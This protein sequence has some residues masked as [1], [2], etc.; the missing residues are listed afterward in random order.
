VQLLFSGAIPGQADE[1]GVTALLGIFDP[2]SGGILHRCEYRPPAPLRVEGQKVQFTGF[3]FDGER[4]FVCSFG[5]I[6]IF[7]SWPPTR[8]A[9]RITHPGFNDLHHCLP[10]RGGLAV[11]NTGLETVDLVS[12]EGELLERWDLLEDEADARRIDAHTD[13]RRILDTKPHRRHVNHLFEVEGELW[14]TQLRSADA[15]RLGDPGRRLE[16]GVGMPHDGRWIGEHLA[17]TT[18]NGRVV[19][20]DPARCEVE[21]SVDLVQLTPGLQQ[22]G[23]CRGICADPRDEQR[24]FV[25]FSTLRRSAW[26]EFGYWIRWRQALPPSRLALY[27]LAAGRQEAAWPLGEAPGHVLFQLDSLPGGRL[28]QMP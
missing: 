15:I 27:D 28:L 19:F 6:L 21:R 9:G 1:R 20:A 18:T 5:E 26:K 23:W 10:W 11:A 17:F 8:P 13:Y 22:L 16:I 12:L 4:L 14:A 25:G 7:D 2:E 24:L 3:S